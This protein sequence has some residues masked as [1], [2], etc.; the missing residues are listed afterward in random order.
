[1]AENVPPPIPSYQETLI[2]SSNRN[3]NGLPDIDKDLESAIKQSLQD[4]D[5]ELNQVALESLLEYETSFDT[6]Y[7]LE[8]MLQKSLEEYEELLT[9]DFT[10]NLDDNLG[11]TDLD[12]TI[13]NVEEIKR[14]R[15]DKLNNFIIQLKRINNLQKSDN[16][17]F[18]IKNLDN[19]M[20]NLIDEIPITEKQYYLLYDELKNIRIENRIYDI[21]KSIIYIKE[22]KG[23][24]DTNC[25][26]V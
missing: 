2:N 12:E 13:Q 8:H 4:A 15:Y 9:C 5:N 21:L 16:L 6:D 1:M 17:S 25:I 3:I 19:Y 10:D 11:D 26:D 20:N 22:K 24:I 7:D 18:L 23:L 14:E